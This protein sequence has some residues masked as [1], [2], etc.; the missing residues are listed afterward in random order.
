M[1]EEI[2]NIEVMEEESS[3]NF[4]KI[5]ANILYK[6]DDLKPLLGLS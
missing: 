2:K 5:S 1:S 3:I 4:G 6:E